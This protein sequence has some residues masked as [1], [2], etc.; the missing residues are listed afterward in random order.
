MIPNGF[1]E[2]TI[3]HEAAHIAFQ[4]Y[5][6]T[7]PWFKVQKKDENYISKYARDYPI[8]EDIAES[9]TVYMGIRLHPERVN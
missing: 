2:E 7:Y 9:F 8:R 5:S 6:L 3:I 1:F 4:K